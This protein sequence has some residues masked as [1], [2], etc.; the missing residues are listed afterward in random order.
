MRGR[1]I[2]VVWGRLIQVVV[3]PWNVERSEPGR[4][5]PSTEEHDVE[6]GVVV[7]AEEEEVQRVGDLVVGGEISMGEPWTVVE[8]EIH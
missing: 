3:G 8:V 6:M 4:H 7:V 1:K 2:L 5:S